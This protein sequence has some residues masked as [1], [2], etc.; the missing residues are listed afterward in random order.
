MEGLS[1][2]YQELIVLKLK[3]EHLLEVCRAL[4]KPWYSAVAIVGNAYFSYSIGHKSH[5]IRLLK[6]PS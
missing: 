6:I 3:Y 5:K 2:H 4:L 1:S